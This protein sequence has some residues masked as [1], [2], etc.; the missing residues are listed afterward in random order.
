MK[1]FTLKNANVAFPDSTHIFHAK[2]FRH[3][4]GSLAGN[5][6]K[7]F[8]VII[9]YKRAVIT[10]NK[11][12]Y[13]NDKFS[14][15]KSGIELAH[16]GFRVISEKDNSTIDSKTGLLQS[17]KAQNGTRIVMDSPYKISLKPAY[18]IVELRDDSPAQKAGLKIGDA[19]L[20]INNKPT[21]QFSL[22]KL[23]QFFYADSGNKIKLV[24][25]REGE[26]L[27]FSFILENMLN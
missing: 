4:N 25:D 7:R 15:N 1:S 12:R 21:Y 19:I 9:D 20:N 27:T 11:N 14:Y 22:Q 13:F 2:R 24:V 5:I 6:L 3:R 8:N 23:I 18:I 10:L 26:V 16:D 17:N